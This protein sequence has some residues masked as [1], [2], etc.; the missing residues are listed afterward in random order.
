MTVIPADI[1]LGLLTLLKANIGATVTIV[2][3]A[4]PSVTGVLASASDNL[5]KIE[6]SGAPPIYCDIRYIVQVTIEVQP[7]D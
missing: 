7:T 1:S 4:C 2:S 3:I 5:V 6:P